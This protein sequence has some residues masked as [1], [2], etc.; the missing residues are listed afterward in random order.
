MVPVSFSGGLDTKSDPHLVQPPR[1]PALVNFRQ[2]ALGGL[3]TRPG[4]TDMGKVGL[5]DTLS[6]GST[7]DE[8]LVADS[9]SLFAFADGSWV[10][11]G[12]Y[13]SSG[14]SIKPIANIALNLL[15]ADLSG[16]IR[17]ISFAVIGDVALAAWD[18]GSDP[19]TK[20]GR[21]YREAQGTVYACAFSVSTGKVIWIDRIDYPGL[22][23]PAIPGGPGGFP[24][25]G[26]YVTPTQGIF[27]PEYH[28][29]SYT[30]SDGGGF[31]AV[32]AF[33]G[34]W[35]VAWL[36]ALREQVLR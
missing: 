28:T 14:V 18:L 3:Q 8:L 31:P 7:N 27:F 26:G 2:T 11:R 23:A 17:N 25:V 32:V 9:Q 15:G 36:R 12:R 34:K 1:C 19:I 4:I 16:T 10:R 35:V 22:V 6:V 20:N 30:H 24:T 5:G 33:K 29:Y 21:T 13:V